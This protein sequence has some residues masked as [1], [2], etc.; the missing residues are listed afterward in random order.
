M[1]R[2]EKYDR[3]FTGFITGFLLPFITGII[4]FIFSSDQKSIPAYL[5]RIADAGI[6]THSISLCVIPNIILFLLYN[7]FDM[8][9][10]SRGV[11]GITL[12]WAL[13]VFGIKLLR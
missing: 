7:R 3:F 13:I 12:I 8:L 10:A 9:R 4:I 5:N 2:I 6:I 11:I 1:T